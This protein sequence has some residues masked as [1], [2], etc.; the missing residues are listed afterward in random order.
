MDFAAVSFPISDNHSSDE[1]DPY[2][3][4]DWHTIFIFKL[5][6]QVCKRFYY[7]MFE[8]E[9]DEVINVTSSTSPLLYWKKNSYH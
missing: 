9:N 4:A 8:T 3:F 5:S 1:R 2:N 6:A 7:L